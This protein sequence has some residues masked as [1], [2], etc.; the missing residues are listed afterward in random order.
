MHRWT[1]ARGAD[2]VRGEGWDGV[3]LEDCK[4]DRGS[5]APRAY[6]VFH[7]SPEQPV[8]VHS[9]PIGILVKAQKKWLEWFFNSATQQR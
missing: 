6:V 4:G 9:H 2:G 7:A 1:G 8:M 3:K 5:Q